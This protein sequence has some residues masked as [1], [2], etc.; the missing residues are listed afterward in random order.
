MV[1]ASNQRVK[2]KDIGFYTYPDVVALCGE[3]EYDDLLHHTLINPQVIIEVLSCGTRNYDR[4]EK[5]ERYRTIQ[6]LSDYV[7]IADNKIHVEHYSSERWDQ[8]ILRESDDLEDSIWVEL[9]DPRTRKLAQE[10]R[11]KP[12]S[13]GPYEIDCELKLKDLYANYDLVREETCEGENL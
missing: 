13:W 3:P 5:F 9:G 6:T 8:W 1:F 11:T 10:P 7:V 12:E 4:G 2:A